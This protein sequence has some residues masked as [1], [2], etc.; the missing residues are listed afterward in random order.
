M[1]VALTS[2]AD[3]S[4]DRNIANLVKTNNMTLV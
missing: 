1:N 3:Y 4:S 2:K